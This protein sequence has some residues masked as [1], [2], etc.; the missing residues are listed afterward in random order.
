MLTPLIHKKGKPT[1][2]K[3][4]RATDHCLEQLLSH[5]VVRQNLSVNK[6]SAK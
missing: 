5:K 6:C 1:Q 3:E 2:L 4:E